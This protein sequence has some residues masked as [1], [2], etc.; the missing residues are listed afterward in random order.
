MK[1][2]R[3]NEIFYSLQGEGV[4]AGTANLFLRFTGC[5]LT[6]KQETHGFDCD[7]EF[8]SGRDLTLDEIVA[9]LAECLE[10]ATVAN[11]NRT[12]NASGALA[13]RASRT[14]RTANHLSSTRTQCDGDQ[15]RGPSV[16][17]EGLDLSRET[18]RNADP[19]TPSPSQGEGWGES[20]PP[21]ETRLIENSQRKP[22][23]RR[24]RTADHLPDREDDVQLVR[25]AG[26]LRWIILTGGE[27]A[28]QVDRELIDALHDA[29]YQL[30]IETN[31]SIALPDGI[32]W[33]TVSPKVAE[34]AIR[35]R[36]ADELKYVRGYGQAIPK[37]V[38]QARYKLISPA[39]DGNVMQQKT[40]AWCSQLVRENPDWRLS[41]QMHKA[42]G[43]R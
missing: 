3:V 29:G 19:T 38:V 42:W 27:P 20:C 26:S 34:H 14:V 16:R 40:L 35:Q 13:A 12:I 5:N 43:V 15:R 17:D 32:N 9:A 30:A 4:R 41:I 18:V 22:T 6:C 23:P 24:V 36:T 39:F 2:Y 25:N 21:G 10:D 28:L 37:T 1:I 33:I 8:A 31:G 11:A 7:T